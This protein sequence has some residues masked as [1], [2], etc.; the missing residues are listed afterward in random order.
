MQKIDSHQHFWKYDPVRDGWIDANMEI[1]RR[2]FLPEDLAPVLK[3]NQFEGCVTVQSDQSEEENAFQL[4]NAEKH[5]FIKGVVGWVDFKA[6]NIEERLE[7]YSEFPKMKGFRH[8]LQGESKRDYMLDPDFMRGIGMLDKYNFVYD[9]LI[10]PDQLKYGETFVKAFPDQL[11]V[12]DHLAKPYIK[13]GKIDEWRKDIE[14][15]AANSN[16]YCKVSGIITE[17]D[18]KNWKKEDLVPYLD[19]IVRAF[20]TERIMFG[21]DW[22][23]CLLAGRYEEVVGLVENYFSSFSA[24]EQASFWGRNAMRFYNI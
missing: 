11:F 17:A 12:I 3:V 23:V 14:S 24:S 16:V 1:I 22:P 18:W 21:S 20:G 13:A 9:V 8:I 15:L 19:A 6:P 4:E 2:D 5:D 7:Y 10:F